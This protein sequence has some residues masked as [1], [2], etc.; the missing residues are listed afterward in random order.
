MKTHAFALLLM[1]ILSL[2]AFAVSSDESQTVSKELEQFLQGAEYVI[3]CEKQEMKLVVIESL[4]GHKKAG[5]I[6]AVYKS[7]LPEPYTIKP[8]A[9]WRDLLI[10]LP[11]ERQLAYYRINNGEID[12]FDAKG[13]SNR[14]VTIETLRRHFIK[15][16]AAKMKN[17]QKQTVHPTTLSAGC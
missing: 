16:R 15:L 2:R 3:V 6:Q 7:N 8:E 1:L 9:T 5:T 17:S 4:L 10:W 12:W 14:K 11:K 13:K